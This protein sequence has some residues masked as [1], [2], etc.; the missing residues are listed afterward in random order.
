MLIN[1]KL[2]FDKNQVVYNDFFENW[3]QSKAWL[4]SII[5]NGLCT[6]EEIVEFIASHEPVQYPCIA[7]FDVKEISSNDEGIVYIYKTQIVEWSKLMTEPEGR[8]P[9]CFHVYLNTP[10]R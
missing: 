3:Y 1:T 7:Y 5:D 8:A 10:K 2:S 6:E 9:K 4:R